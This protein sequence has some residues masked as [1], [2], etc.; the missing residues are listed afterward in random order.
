[1][2]RFIYTRHNGII[3][4][5]L[6]ELIDQKIGKNFPPVAPRTRNNNK[7]LWVIV[8]RLT[9]GI[10]DRKDSTPHSIETFCDARQTHEQGDRP[11]TS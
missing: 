1:M 6:A 5:E 3:C 8:D 2:R 10:K 11:N 9:N 4:A 7:A